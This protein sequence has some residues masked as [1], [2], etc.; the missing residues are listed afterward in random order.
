MIWNYALKITPYSPP[1]LTT[2]EFSD[3]LQVDLYKK[4]NIYHLVGKLSQ[5]W[6]LKVKNGLKSD[7]NR[8]YLYVSKSLT[9][10]FL[11]IEKFSIHI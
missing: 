9:Y 1:L 11:L 10:V 5:K 2:T 6:L 4:S 3:I 8:S 7:N